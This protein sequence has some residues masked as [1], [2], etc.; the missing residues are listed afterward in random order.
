MHS[1][2]VRIMKTRHTRTTDNRSL[3]AD[4]SEVIATDT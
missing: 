4:T 3:A 1:L 2:M